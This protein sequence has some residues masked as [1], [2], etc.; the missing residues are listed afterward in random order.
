MKTEKQKMLDG[1]LYDCAD[2]ELYSRW[3]DAKCLQLDF[4]NTPVTM[5]GKIAS[6]LDK[7]IGSRG[8]D[9]SITA[10]IYVDYGD[11][12]HIGN[13]VEINMNCVFLDCNTITIGDFS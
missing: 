5:N 11:N 12:I 6:I 7:L 1:E 9:V 3:Q 4:N 13:N 2:N 8:V 10:P